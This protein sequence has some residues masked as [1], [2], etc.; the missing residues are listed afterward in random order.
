MERV[1]AETW[2]TDLPLSAPKG[3][4]T[5]LPPLHWKLG[6]GR[7][8]RRRRVR[9]GGRFRR[10]TGRPGLLDRARPRWYVPVLAGLLL[11]LALVAD[12]LVLVTGVLPVLAVCGW[13]AC[14]A[15]AR[16]KQARSPWLD[17]ALAG[18][19][20]AA[21]TIRLVASAATRTPAAPARA[22]AGSSRTLLMIE[23]GRTDIDP[24]HSSRGVSAASAIG[25]D[26]AN[27]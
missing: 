14:A 22:A 12:Q 2:S 1:G 11:T 25:C 16:R 26:H 7:E 24:P 20:A 19:A 9:G 21:E 4:H 23:P 17:L 8:H 10:A 3:R 6:V 13:R 18:V 15:M 27:G 5:Q